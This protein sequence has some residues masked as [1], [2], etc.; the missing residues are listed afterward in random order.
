[1]RILIL[2]LAAIL[3]FLQ[4]RLWFSDGG[5]REK[6][7]LES[8]ITKHQQNNS[9][10]RK[11]NLILEKEVRD[12]KKGDEVIERRA[13]EDLGLIK[14]DEIFFQFV[15]PLDSRHSQKTIDRESP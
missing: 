14:A 7:L 9:E 10:L 4:S 15:E 8:Q 6:S 5:L 1:M 2:L 11:R 12:L 3:V 13:R